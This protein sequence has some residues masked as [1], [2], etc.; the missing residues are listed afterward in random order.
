[1]FSTQINLK[2]LTAATKG[3]LGSSRILLAATRGLSTRLNKSGTTD[4]QNEQFEAHSTG[5]HRGI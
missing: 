2:C 5:R 1:M 4:R 3:R